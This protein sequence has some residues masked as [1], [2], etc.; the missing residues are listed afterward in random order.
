M[1]SP[2]NLRLFI[3]Y[4]LPANRLGQR[5]RDAMSAIQ[6]AVESRVTHG[7]VRW[8]P[9]IKLHIT[10]RFIGDYPAEKLPDLEAAVRQSVSEQPPFEMT[11]GKL[12]IKSNRMIWLVPQSGLDEL[13][14][15]NRHVESAMKALKLQPS[16]Q[17]SG[18]ITLARLRPQCHLEA[19]AHVIDKQ[20]FPV[21]PPLTVDR[22]SIMSSELLPSG[23]RYTCLQQ[24]VFGS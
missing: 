23:S 7:T 11:F 10:L 5:Y 6:R 19:L 16:Q 18:H 21:I 14:V 13:G 20:V 8:E 2:E 3:A 15:L 17:F 12:Q 9:A 1:S 24:I 4:E 22:L